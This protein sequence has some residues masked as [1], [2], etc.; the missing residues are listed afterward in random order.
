MF[1]IFNVEFETVMSLVSQ[2]S[3]ERECEKEGSRKSTSK[4]FWDLYDIKKGSPFQ[5]ILFKYYK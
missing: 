3:D 4:N 2:I 1:L 5:N